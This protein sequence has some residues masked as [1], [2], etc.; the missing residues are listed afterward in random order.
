MIY[1]GDE[2]C[3]TE[4]YKNTIG[5]VIQGGGQRRFFY[6]SDTHQPK[7]LKSWNMIAQ[8]IEKN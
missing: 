6:I 8:S 4:N 5:G 7:M 1:G 2:T 3:Q